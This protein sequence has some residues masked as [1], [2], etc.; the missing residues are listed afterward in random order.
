MDAFD[1]VF[2]AVIVVCLVGIVCI[3]SAMLLDVRHRR[4]RLLM[5][6]H[7]QTIEVV[8]WNGTARHR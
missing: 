2:L 6:R 4:E 3:G 8:D 1:V 5:K 7:V